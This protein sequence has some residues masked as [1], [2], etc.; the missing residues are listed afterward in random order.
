MESFVLSETWKY[1]HLLHS[2]ASRLADFFVLSTEG[3]LM[4]PLAAPSDSSGAQPHAQAPCWLASSAP[5]GALSGPQRQLRCEIPAQATCTP[6]GQR[7]HL[8]PLKV[9]DPHGRA[10]H[11]RPPPRMAAAPCKC[12]SG[13][14]TA[15][16]GRLALV[17]MGACRSTAGRAARGGQGSQQPVLRGAVPALE[18]Q[19]RSVIARS[20]QG[21]AQA[22]AD[23]GAGSNAGDVNPASSQTAALPGAARSQRSHPLGTAGPCKTTALLKPADG[24]HRQLQ[25]AQ[26]ELGEAFP[27][28]PLQPGA[29]GVLR[30][31]RCAAC[32]RVTQR[33][34]GMTAGALPCLSP[35]G[36]GSRVGGCASCGACPA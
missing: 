16:S 22:Q 32:V 6:V 27:H 17:T 18:P 20:I 3:H 30:A 14:S 15:G 7:A 36:L 2:N 26:D 23:P 10:Q 35:Q 31:R 24:L 4:A 8:I 28:L 29:P 25:A 13:G 12:S 5:D 19:V 9:S 21:A 34:A 33:M 11:Q 1:L